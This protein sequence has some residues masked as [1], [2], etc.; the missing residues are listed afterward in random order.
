MN[1]QNS[2]QSQVPGM[3]PV[4]V[5]KFP[6]ESK[7]LEVRDGK[8]AKEDQQKMQDSETNKN[9]KVIPNG[10]ELN[11]ASEKALGSFKSPKPAEDS[12]S[13]SHSAEAGK[14]VKDKSGKL[15]SKNDG[16]SKEAIAFKALVH[17]FCVGLRTGHILAAFKA[18]ACAEDEDVLRN[19]CSRILT[20]ARHTITGRVVTTASDSHMLYHHQNISYRNHEL[21]FIVAVHSSYRGDPISQVLNHFIRTYTTKQDLATQSMAQNGIH[22]PNAPLTPS[23]I[24]PTQIAQG[25][26]MAQTSQIPQ[27]TQ[28]ILQHQAAAAAA[29]AAHAQF[30]TMYPSLQIP[31]I[32]QT[33]VSNHLQSAAV[34]VTHPQSAAARATP[35]PQ[36][37]SV[38]EASSSQPIDSKNG[39]L[40]SNE[41]NNRA[42]ANKR[43]RNNDVDNISAEVAR[44]AA[45]YK[46]QGQA[47]PQEQMSSQL[48]SPVGAQLSS[49]SATPEVTMT[50]RETSDNKGSD[51]SA[52][53]AE[54]ELAKK[55]IKVFILIKEPG[56]YTAKMYHNSKMEHLGTFDTDL[57]AAYA[58]DLEAIRIGKTSFNLHQ[59]ALLQ[60]FLQT[61]KANGYDNNQIARSLL[62]TFL[63]KSANIR[64]MS[65][66]GQAALQSIQQNIGLQSSQN[67]NP[68][69][70]LRPEQSI[71]TPEAL[72][73]LQSNSIDNKKRAAATTGSSV[74]NSRPQKRSKA[75]LA[76][77][78][79]ATNKGVQ[80]QNSAGAVAQPAENIHVDRLWTQ[81]FNNLKPQLDAQLH[82]W[83]ALPADPKLVV[84]AKGTRRRR[85][86]Q[87]CKWCHNHKL[88]CV[89]NPSG[90]RYPCVR[91]VDSGF[92][93]ECGPWFPDERKQSDRPKRLAD[94][95]NVHKGIP[96]RRNPYCVRPHRHPG[97][98]KE[99]M[100][101]L[102][103]ANK[104]V[105]K[106]NDRTETD[107]KDERSTATHQVLPVA[108]IS[109]PVAQQMIGTAQSPITQ[110]TIV[111]PQATM[112]SGEVVADVVRQPGVGQ[113]AVA[114]AP[115]VMPPPPGMTQP[116]T[117]VKP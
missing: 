30:L 48:E 15:S 108:M 14:A 80:V 40:Q 101:L 17:F 4:L 111:A 37:S 76:V 114:V 20:H 44:L 63:A 21:T 41:E 27:A 29:A 46:Q 6:G 82:G 31:Q 71:L 7:K 95:H 85:A 100:N 51:L 16:D 35:I 94:E 18:P 53:I 54:R 49:A 90:A 45:K 72:R 38:P 43:R 60:K 102:L 104:V 11:G 1:V 115:Q 70:N 59:S 64:Q 58:Y 89:P 65:V 99:R 116:A 3:P 103:K 26:Q 25:T 28:L 69:L 112:A 66:E 105:N 96:C 75:E 50:Q 86:R 9:S 13:N 107:K 109:T 67:Q 77:D 19:Q 81:R 74:E 91:C 106:K 36:Q 42:Q 32:A 79:A 117:V 98:C 110:S 113:G 52:Q 56:K 84:E 57:E 23:M 87:A 2:F 83:S 8:D 55:N 10:N 47:V 5:V 34:R 61:A 93:K 97:H 68:I 22:I 62:T 78:K 39:D 12:T 73:A 88:R 24:P 92:A 33:I